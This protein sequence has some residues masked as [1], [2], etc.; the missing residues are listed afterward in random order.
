LAPCV[1]LGQGRMAVLDGL[2]RASASQKGS[3][4]VYPKIE[5]RWDCTG[6]L[7]QDTFVTLNNDFNAD[8]DIQ[9]FLICETGSKVN[10]TFTLT[11]NEATYWSACTGHPMSLSPWTVLDEPYADPEGSDDLVLRGHLLLWAIDREYQEI[12]WNHLYG[13]ATIVNYRDGSAWEYN[14]YAFPVVDPF[15]ENGQPSGTP[16]MLNLDGEEYAFGL[17]NLLL[18][19]FAS[20]STGLSS[21]TYGV[22]VDT[23]LTLLIL[24]H[25]LRQEG[26][27]PRATKASFDVWNANE[28][29]FSGMEHCV[30]AWDQTLL[31]LLGGHFLRQNLHTDKGCARI[32]GLASGLCTDSTDESLLG[33]AAKMLFADSEEISASGTN[34][35]GAGEMAAVIEYDVQELSPEKADRDDSG[36]A[37]GSGAGIQGRR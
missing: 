6:E 15:V 21:D 34:L 31:G 14:A 23:D 12:R 37:E 2:G 19:F 29:R 4:L 30:Y 13:G 5:I 3:L 1:V 25:D 28:V 8:V 7:V 20:G 22:T 11:Q 33:V 16:G 9:M 36:D 35:A 24:G 10:N 27:G 18:D 26:T 17:S 32:T